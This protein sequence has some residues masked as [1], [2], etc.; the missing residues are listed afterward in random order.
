MTKQ[1]II[2]ELKFGMDTHI[3]NGELYIVREETL[4]RIIA[5]DYEDI[6]DRIKVSKCEN[7]FVHTH[8]EKHPELE[9]IWIIKGEIYFHFPNQYTVNTMIYHCLAKSDFKYYPKL[10][11][12][13]EE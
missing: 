13:A 11:E 10:K 6:V 12:N 4:E 3:I 8:L 1:K 2:A 9:Y 5:K 7:V